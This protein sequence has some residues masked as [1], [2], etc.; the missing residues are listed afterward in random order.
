M[1]NVSNKAELQNTA[2]EIVVALCNF[3]Q[4]LNTKEAVTLFNTVSYMVTKE[5]APD[6]TNM[7]DYWQQIANSLIMDADQLFD[8][9]FSSA[10]QYDYNCYKDFKKIAIDVEL[11]KNDIVFEDGS[12]IIVSVI[13]ENNNPSLQ[14]IVNIANTD[15][16]TCDY[17]E[18]CRFLWEN[19]SKTSYGVE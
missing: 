12:Y 8:S 4:E 19:H 11:T 5:P 16:V 10:R 15:F 13:F 6:I 18:A 17:G 14:Y 1:T 3:N 2:L 7:I 9:W